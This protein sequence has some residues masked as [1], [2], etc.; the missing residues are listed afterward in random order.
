[1]GVT[2]ESEANAIRAEIARIRL[3]YGITPDA[4][5]SATDILL[6]KSPNDFRPHRMRLITLQHAASNHDFKFIGKKI[7]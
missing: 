4:Y 6:L 2:K 1:M 5:K 7:S 3:N